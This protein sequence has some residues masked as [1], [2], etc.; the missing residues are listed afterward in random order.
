M[1]HINEN[2]EKTM[3]GRNRS[4]Y[5][6]AQPDKDGIVLISEQVRICVRCENKLNKVGS[7]VI[8]QTE[9]FN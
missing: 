1:I 9:Y 2:N 3:C 8:R 7:G 4:D 5:L 6:T